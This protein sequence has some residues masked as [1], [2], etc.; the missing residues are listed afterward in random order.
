MNAS[1]RY[2]V[3]TGGVGGAKLALG[4]SRILPDDRLTAIVNT[5]DDFEHQLAGVHN[6]ERAVLQ[7]VG[8]STVGSQVHDHPRRTIRLTVVHDSQ[9]V[10]MPNAGEG[11]GLG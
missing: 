1:D 5:G 3:L 10:R 11:T 7:T 4:L 9:H 2:I 8:E 6:L